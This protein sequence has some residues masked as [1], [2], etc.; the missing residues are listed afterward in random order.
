MTIPYWK[1]E[2]IANFK[3]PIMK[4]IKEL[5]NKNRIISEITCES[6]YQQKNT[7][8]TIKFVFKGSEDCEIN[9]RK[10]SIY[11]DTFAVFNEG[12]NFISRVDSITPVNTL[13]VSFGHQFITDFHQTYCNTHEQQLD[14]KQHSSNPM[15]VESLYPFGGDMRFNMLHLKNQIDNG[16]SDEMLINEYMYHCLFNYYKIYNTEFTQKLDRLSFAK[17][18]TKEEILKRLTLA[19]EY[20]SSNFNQKLTLEDIADQACLS[21][22]HLLRTFKEAYDMSPYQFLMKLRL[23]RAKYLLQTT[24]YPLHEIVNLIGFEC[25]SSFIRLFKSTFNI[26]PLKYKKSRLN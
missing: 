16:Q 13:S 24:S 5:K 1:K 14:G 15:F 18:K 19:K 9:K 21:V 20:I 11:P 7:G 17:T 4:L 12:S 22:N 26:T 3:L 6:E 23:H 2:A 25:S 10:L 8:C